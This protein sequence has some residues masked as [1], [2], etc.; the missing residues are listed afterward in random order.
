MPWLP[1]SRSRASIPGPRG[2]VAWEVIERVPC[3]FQLLR[4]PRIDASFHDFDEYER[5]VEAAKHTDERAHLTVLLGGEAGLRCGEIMAL[6]WSDIDFSKRQLRVARSDWKGRVT[7]PKGGRPR[8]IPMTR[9]LAEALQAH[10][11]LRGPRVMYQDAGSPLT[12]KVVQNLVRRAARRANLGNEG[13][14][15]LRHT[16]CSHLAM[17]GA[18][19]KAIQELAGHASLGT[20][21]GYMHLSP[22]AVESAIR[23]LE[24]PVPPP[25]FGD[26]VETGST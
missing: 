9:R 4:V 26:I 24:M 22:A 17:R 8:R 13:V 10:R 11:H 21:Q 16:F 2:A 7:T 12:Q 18:P 6:E 3:M 1:F 23:L 15:V 20:T 5:L 25:A 14:H 19:A